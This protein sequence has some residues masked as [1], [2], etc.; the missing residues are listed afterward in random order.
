[1]KGYEI[2]M[3]KKILILMLAIAMLSGCGKKKPANND[4]VSSSPEASQATDA[5][6]GN[7]DGDNN[8]GKGSEKAKDNSTPKPLATADIKTGKKDPNRTPSIPETPDPSKVVKNSGKSAGSGVR[9]GEVSDDEIKATSADN[10]VKL[11]MQYMKKN[12]IYIPQKVE[13]DSEEDDSYI[14]HAYEVM[15]DSTGEHT[16]SV[17]WFKV[18]KS[19][20][21]V[22]RVDEDIK[23]GQPPESYKQ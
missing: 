22:T 3:L 19:T 14:I 7:S 12:N 21:E 1:M 17:G 18:S 15:K 4:S 16:S 11:A 9:A 2:T 20:S 8:G 5:D 6:N 10:A 13:L 23:V